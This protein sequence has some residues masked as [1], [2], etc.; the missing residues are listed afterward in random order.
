MS[1]RF[2]L[3]YV[4]RRLVIMI[5]IIKLACTVCV[6][7]ACL[8]NRTQFGKVAAY[9]EV[10]KFDWIKVGTLNHECL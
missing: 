5:I 8:G 4:V 3:G 9:I 6:V 2:I 10:M 1:V 7:N